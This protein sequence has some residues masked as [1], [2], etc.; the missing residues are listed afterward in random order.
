MKMRN[1]GVIVLL[2]GVVLIV[3]S[4]GIL[5]ATGVIN[6]KSNYIEDDNLPKWANYLL[7]QNITEITYENGIV[8]GDM[9]ECSAAKEMTKE[10]LKDVLLRMTKSELKKYDAGGFGGP[11]WSGIIVKYNGK[12][13]RLFM[14][15][16]IL[17]SD[18]DSKI[19]S[20]LEREAYIFENSSMS[21]PLWV[22]E[23]NWDTSYIDALFQ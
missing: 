17:L 19:I 18:N 23:Y 13:F 8:F 11:C 22:Y 21:D 2:I 3:L 9:E 20:L 15:K 4:L 1:N 16:Y 7:S 6:F 12:E 10:Q 14:G 5:F